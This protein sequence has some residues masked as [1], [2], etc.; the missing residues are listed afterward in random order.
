MRATEAHRWVVAH[1]LDGSP[2]LPARCRQLTFGGRCHQHV[3]HI[4]DRCGK[5][6]CR[7]HVGPLRAV[8]VDAWREAPEVCRTCQ[9][10]ERHVGIDLRAI[11]AAQRRAFLVDTAASAGVARP[12]EIED[13]PDLPTWPPP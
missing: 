11:S 8:D 10:L 4:C 9:A 3:D 7:G 6:V 5:P 2:R 12:T 13:Y 1:G